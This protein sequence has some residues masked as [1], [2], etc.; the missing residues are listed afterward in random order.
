MIE[1]WES[2]DSSACFNNYQPNNL[3]DEVTVSLKIFI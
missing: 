1:H 2:R 3:N